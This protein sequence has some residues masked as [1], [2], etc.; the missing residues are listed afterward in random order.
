M[1][2]DTRIEPQIEPL[3]ILTLETRLKQSVI[4][5]PLGDRMIFDAPAG[6]FGWLNDIQAFGMGVPIR[7]GVRYQFFYFK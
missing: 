1:S 3:L 6:A 2:T 4:A 7:D 5:T